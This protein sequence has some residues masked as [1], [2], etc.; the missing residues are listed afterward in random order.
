MDSVRRPRKS[1]FSQA[2]LLG[3]RSLELREDVA[4]LVLAKRDE[5]VERLIGDDHAG[6]V[7]AGVAAE[8]P[9]SFFAVSISCVSFGSPS[10]MS[11]SSLT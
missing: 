5:F 7:H 4:F 9:S 3:D 11:R 8:G 6:R 10:T 1:I 2:A